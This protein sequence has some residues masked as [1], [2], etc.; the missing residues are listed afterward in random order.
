MPGIE[1]VDDVDAPVGEPIN[2]DDGPELTGD[3]ASNLTA[4]LGGAAKNLDGTTPG[5][6]R[7]DSSRPQRQAKSEIDGEDEDLDDEDDEDE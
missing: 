4:A 7:K 6:K 5:A 3:L 1:S 2:L